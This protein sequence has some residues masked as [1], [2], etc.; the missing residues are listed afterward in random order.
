MHRLV[1]DLVQI[2]NKEPIKIDYTTKTT[3]FELFKVINSQE[4]QHIFEK[5]GCNYYT[6]K[7]K[8]HQ[9]IVLLILAQQQQ[10][11]GVRAMHTHLKFSNK[12]HQ[13]LGIDEIS[14]TQIFRRLQ[15]FPASAIEEIFEVVLKALI[16]KHH[17][18][19]IPAIQKLNL[20]DAST[21]SKSLSGMEWAQFR[22]DKAGIK[23]H[24]SLM[25]HDS[26]VYPSKLKVTSAK[27][28]DVLYLKDLVVNCSDTINVF[29]RGYVDY[30]AFDEF[31]ETGI[32]FV[33]RLKDN[34]STWVVERLLTLPESNVIYDDLVK[35]GSGQKKTQNIFRYIQLRD[36][37]GKH[38]Q[39]ITNV[40]DL[41][42]EDIGAIYKN[43]WQIELFFKW[44][45]QNLSI[46]HFY[47]TSK[48]AI[49]VQVYVAMIAYCLFT[50]V[51]IGMKQKLSLSKIKAA[52]LAALYEPLDEFIERLMRISPH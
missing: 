3:I 48:D 29:D 4:V 38:I 47:A 9:L 12:L 43:R 39:F 17:L 37:K 35:V 18:C 23:L 26:I 36:D 11:T 52:V 5:H 21:I 49:T 42:A 51:A 13:Y 19:S 34:A 40:M 33:T 1:C 30:K 20:I 10:S 27:E 15:K 50:M 22:K 44:I 41:S 6:K 2:Y 7:L 32:K 31:A 25:Y 24:L 46:K 8:A 16:Q 28:H 45:K 14:H